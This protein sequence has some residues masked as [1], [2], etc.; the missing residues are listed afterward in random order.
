MFCITFETGNDLI[1]WNTCVC[2][3][4]NFSLKLIKFF[5]DKN[6]DLF[7]FGTLDRSLKDWETETSNF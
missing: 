1:L 5:D 2:D 7:Y 6:I 3:S 4:S